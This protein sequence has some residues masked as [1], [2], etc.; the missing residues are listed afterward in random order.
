MGNMCQ[1]NLHTPFTILQVS[2]SSS[3]HPREQDPCHSCCASSNAKPHSCPKSLRSS[4]PLL[5]KLCTSQSMD[6]FPLIKDSKLNMKLYYFF[7]WQH[8]KA[9]LEDL[10]LPSFLSLGSCSCVCYPAH[11]NTPY[12]FQ[13][14][15]SYRTLYEAHEAEDTYY[16]L[17]FVWQSHWK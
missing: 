2:F 17:I 6:H 11:L 3:P 16:A 12:I 5:V 13:C 9:L 10:T 15:S 1:E 8:Q 4:A 7:T 14:G